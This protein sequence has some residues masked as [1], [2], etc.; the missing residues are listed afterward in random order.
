MSY[1]NECKP[2]TEDEIKSKINHNYEIKQKRYNKQRNKK[3]I[4]FYR[5]AAW[6]LSSRAKL[7]SVNYKCEA[8]LEGCT[9]LAVEVHHKKPIQTEEGW[10]LRLEWSNFEAVCIN[11]HNKRRYDKTAKIQN[12][13]IDLKRV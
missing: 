8:Q 13:V 7:D 5:S 1:C 6:K 2:I 9:G 12:G 4:E 10:E 3:Y 11:C